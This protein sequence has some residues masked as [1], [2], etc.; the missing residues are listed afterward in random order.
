MYQVFK[1]KFPDNDLAGT[2]LRSLG[3]PPWEQFGQN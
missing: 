2:E 3:F 1:N